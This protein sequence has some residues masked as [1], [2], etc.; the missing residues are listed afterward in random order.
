MNN[1]N[2]ISNKERCPLFDSV[3][4][5]IGWKKKDFYDQMILEY[6]CKYPNIKHSEYWVWFQHTAYYKESYFKKK[7]INIKNSINNENNN[8]NNKPLKDCNT[9]N[10]K[11]PLINIISRVL[12]RYDLSN[13]DTLI[14][15]LNSSALPSILHKFP[16]GDCL[17]FII[18]INNTTKKFQ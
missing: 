13:I 14:D 6:I 16:L 17:R 15:I 5:D 7:I 18:E 1:T 9:R 3:H 10:T 8:S 2:P 12:S 4:E 11:Y